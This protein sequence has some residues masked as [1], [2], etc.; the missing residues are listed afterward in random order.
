MTDRQPLHPD[1]ET[2]RYGPKGDGDRFVGLWLALVMQGRQRGSISTAR[3]TRRIL[4]RFYAGR[5]VRAAVASLGQPVVDDQ[6][7]QAA[8]VYFHSCLVDPQY[9]NTLWRMNR[10]EPTKLR[11]RMAGDTADTLAIMAASGGLT[12]AARRLPALLIDGFLDTLAP[13]GA[14]E[15]SRAIA[16]NELARRAMELS[17][18]D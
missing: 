4:D 12:G 15:L 10:I 17:A 9:S 8:A 7:R 3:Q 16:R 13:E 11:V 6:L 2:A 5:E 1:L 18:D 14:E